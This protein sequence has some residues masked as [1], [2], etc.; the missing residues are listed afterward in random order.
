MM[1]SKKRKRKRRNK[2]RRTRL[3]IF[4]VAAVLV[5]ALAYLFFSGWLDQW[6]GRR[7]RYSLE[8]SG[9]T[10]PFSGE[11][12]TVV[13]G[14]GNLVLRVNGAGVRA[15][16]PRGET[17]WDI[18]FSMDDPHLAVAGNYLA[19]A[20]YGGQT[21]VIADAQGHS[22][23]IGFA[24]G[25]RI[26]FHSV[27]E[28][29]ELI[30]V[31]LGEKE[32]EL[33]VYAGKADETGLNWIRYEKVLSRRTYQ[34]KDGIPLAAALSAD[35]KRL[36]T[37][38]FQ[39]YGSRFQS[40]LTCF[41]LSAAGADLVDRILGSVQLP[42]ELVTELGFCGGSCLFAS[43]SSFGA[44]SVDKGCALAWQN[45][46]EWKLSAAVIGEDSI[47]VALGERKAGSAKE[48]EKNFFIYNKEGS[49]V[50]AASVGEVS[51]LTC[52]AGIY[53]CGSD[54]FY[55]AVSGRGKNLWSYDCPRDFAK[56][57]ALADRK[58]VAARGS[59]GLVFY[60]VKEI[61]EAVT[62]D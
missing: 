14:L 13:G 23:E 16:D 7:S 55:T 54:H 32:N 12:E 61:M 40:V 19:V 59:D 36:V 8:A 47:A 53:V 43:D 30:L 52:N 1:T 9:V 45:V 37:S 35:G 20:D 49:E 22:S 25:D 58:T 51:S 27:S 6:T 39:Y 31:S 62:D 17:A 56:L 38:Y 4:A 28:S 29:G 57:I 3:W 34:A 46:P 26:M 21:V 2:E 50:Y 18:G 15:V 41:D 10:V 60:Q 24:A 42:D 5:A 44:L 33:S 48:A 11:S